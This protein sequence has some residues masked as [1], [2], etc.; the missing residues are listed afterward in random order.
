MSNLT[1]GFHF[2]SKDS[3]G[4]RSCKVR[5]LRTRD[6]TARLGMSLFTTTEAHILIKCH[7]YNLRNV[8]PS[9]RNHNFLG[10]PFFSFPALSIQCL[11][12]IAC[13]WR[14]FHNFRAQISHCIIT[15]TIQLKKYTFT[16]N[17]TNYSTCLKASVKESYQDVQGVERSAKHPGFSIQ[18]AMLWGC[19]FCHTIPFA[20]HLTSASSHQPEAIK[21]RPNNTLAFSQD[22]QKR[23]F[24]PLWWPTEK[25]ITP[26]R[27]SGVFFA[28]KRLYCNRNSSIGVFC[29]SACAN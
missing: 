28:L 29:S 5:C 25:S 13:I 15:L 12:S 24:S 16:K 22:S 3:L 10:C 27:S 14:G 1:P 21:G 9:L 20:R 4:L 6:T 19:Q 26:V 18:S 7:N 23:T 11:P 17:H 2:R 8:A